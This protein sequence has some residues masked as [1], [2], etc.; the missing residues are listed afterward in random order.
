MLTENVNYHT[1][2]TLMVHEGIKDRT[3]LY[4]DEREKNQPPGTRKWTVN[5][6]V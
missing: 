3:T 4:R 2:P 6:D 1:K 5:I